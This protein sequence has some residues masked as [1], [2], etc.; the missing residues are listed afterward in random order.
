MKEVYTVLEELKGINTA[1][2]I[3]TD[4][5]SRL[6]A[7]MSEAK[8]CTPIIGK[9]SSGKSALVN[10]ILGYS[11]KILREDITPETAIP[12]EIVYSESEDSISI[13]KNDGSY[14][15]LDVDEYRTFEADANT[16]KSARI[17]LR[18][19][20]L[21][22][23]PDVMIVD[24]PGFESGFEIHNKAID[25]YLPQS[26][27]Y[28][29]AIPADDMI[30][31]S[32]VG[33]ILKELH[34]NDVPLCVV[35][36]KYDKRNDD[37]ESTFQKMKESLKRF[38]GDSE[39]T[40][41]KTSSFTGDAE[42]L[43]EFLIKIQE[44]SQDILAH[45]YK[46]LALPLVENTRNYLITTL[47][48]SDL[49]ESELDEKEEKLERQKV[50]LE[51]KFTKEK[52]NF[53]IEIAECIEEIKSDVQFALEAEESTFVAMVLNN[54]KIDQ[55]LNSVVRNAVTAS[56]K[57]R[58]I[59]RVEKYIR[60]IENVFKSESVGDINFSFVFDT[61]KLS[62]GM[63]GS[64][65]AGVATALLSTSGIAGLIVGFIVKKINDKRREKAKQEVTEKLN[66]EVFPQVL[67]EV[68]NN[69]EMEIT[70][71]VKLINTSIEEDFT[72][73]RETLEKAMADLRQQ[74]KDE[75]SKK[76]NLAVDIN[77]DLARIERIEDDLR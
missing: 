46:K 11:R 49:S 1:Y 24:M 67:R 29:I 56:V 30:I 9:F 38:V 2:G 44:E 36:T 75:Q 71:Q 57:K 52:E 37:F 25:N 74:K 22:K 15:Q 61:Y 50:S 27:A 4:G 6:Q 17:K 65:V 39:I 47:K 34:L 69:I 63:T 77:E 72:N 10:T 76:E 41:C 55:Q 42:E 23:I 58:F 62:R 31:R 60:K 5:I 18:N 21:E 12:A 35:I 51:D 54:Q 13:I 32:S 8:V 66:T 53:D 26:L 16:V 48:G 40:Y 59:P 68:G 28:I 20:F 73:Q 45:K 7:E 70:K 43:E 14:K 19:S 33:N 3:D 64:I